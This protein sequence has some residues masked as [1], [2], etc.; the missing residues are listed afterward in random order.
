MQSCLEVRLDSAR[1]D[2][3]LHV[4]VNM[5]TT[6][7]ATLDSQQLIA[8]RMMVKMGEMSS[9]IKSIAESKSASE[10]ISA[11]IGSLT[12]DYLTCR[13]Q[14][15][16][17]IKGALLD[18]LVTNIHGSQG[19]SDLAV[20]S[21]I[22]LSQDTRHKLEQVFIH[23]LRYDNMKERESTINKPTKEHFFGLSRTIRMYLLQR[24]ISEPGWSLMSSSTGLPERQAQE[25]RP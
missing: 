23:R 25:S 16:D 3:V 13:L 18:A 14:E 4:T 1:L 19:Q 8:K 10:V 20:P 5:R 7:R 22:E 21:T 11:G 6:A 17:E 24:R 9:D 15:Q 12:L 2:L